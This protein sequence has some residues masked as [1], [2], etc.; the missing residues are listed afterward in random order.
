MARYCK[1]CGA[2][3]DGNPRFCGNCGRSCGVGVVQSRNTSSGFRHFLAGTDVGALFSHL[4][5]GSASAS[6]SHSPYAEPTEHYHD[7]LIYTDGEDADMRVIMMGLRM[8]PLMT[9][10]GT[11]RIPPIMMVGIRRI[12]L[13]TMTGMQMLPMTGTR[14]ISMTTMM[15]GTRMIPMRTMMTGTR[16]ITMMMTR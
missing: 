11:G 8:I 9:P 15:I 16:R 4:F 13:T 10:A 7:S 2:R 12:P 5:G 3:L 6:A 1:N 14:M